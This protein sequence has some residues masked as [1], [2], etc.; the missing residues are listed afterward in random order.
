MILADWIVNRKPKITPHSP[1]QYVGTYKGYPTKYFSTIPEAEAYVQHCKE[2]D[3]FQGNDKDDWV[4][5]TEAV[6]YRNKKKPINPTLNKWRKDNLAILEKEKF[7]PLEKGDICAVALVT[8]EGFEHCTGWQTWIVRDAHYDSKT[9]TFDV[10]AD[11]TIIGLFVYKDSQIVM[12]TKSMPQHF[13]YAGTY[14]ITL[15]Y[16]WSKG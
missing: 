16:R 13:E 8:D 10:P 9:F 11:T 7:T 14:T 12:S 4:K 1:V 15:N 5:A 6:K 2:E 3:E